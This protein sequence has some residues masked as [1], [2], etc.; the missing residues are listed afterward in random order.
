MKVEN[1]DVG[2][3]Q[4]MKVYQQRNIMIMITHGLNLLMIMF[5]SDSEL[6]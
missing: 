2:A 4:M 1:I 3:R 5:S 6:Y